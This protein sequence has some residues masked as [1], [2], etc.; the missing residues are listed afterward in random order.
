MLWS[1]DG[2]TVFPN[3][4]GNSPRT[5]E[6]IAL[7][8]GFGGRWRGQGVAAPRTFQPATT[9]TSEQAR[10]CPSFRQ[11][12]SCAAPRSQSRGARSAIAC[13]A[14]AAGRSALDGDLG[15]LKAGA[16]G[17]WPFPRRRARRA[18]RRP[19]GDGR[20]LGQRK[21][22]SPPW[23]AG[24]KA[25]LPVRLRRESRGCLRPPRRATPAASPRRTRCLARDHAPAGTRRARRALEDVRK[26]LTSF[27]PAR[28]GTGVSGLVRLRLMVDTAPGAVPLDT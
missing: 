11:A 3:R 16:P 22:G 13:D 23:A 8:R 6:V 9:T 10:S 7:V 21:G 4:G 1:R 25:E 17:G 19:T 24:A 5:G 20:F 12:R 28:P 18:Y 15:R 14:K 26:V 2:K 27:G